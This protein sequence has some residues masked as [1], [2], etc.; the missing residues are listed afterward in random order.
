MKMG[1]IGSDTEAGLEMLIDY[2]RELKIK[3][4]EHELLNLGRLDEGG[5]GITLFEGYS[6]RCVRKNDK[7]MVQGYSRYAIALRAAIYGNQIKLLDTNPP[8]DF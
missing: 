8:C 7:H 6:I 4:P 3:N 5:R 2:Y 1:D